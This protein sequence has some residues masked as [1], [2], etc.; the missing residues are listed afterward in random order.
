MSKIIIKKGLNSIFIGI[1]LFL[2]SVFCFLDTELPIG[3]T[4]IK[5]KLG[6]I[7]LGILLFLFT[8]LV[9]FNKYKKTLTKSRFIFA[10]ETIL[11]ILL[12]LTGFFL[13]AMGL[14]S[15]ET[16]KNEHTFIAHFLNFN[17][18]LALLVLVHSFVS[19]HIE[20]FK[21]EK[22][23]SFTFYLVMFGCGSYAIGTEL[24]SRNTILKTLAVLSF[25][26][27]LFHFFVAIQ[28]MK[29]H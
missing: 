7:F 4:T 14:C 2:V 1:L 13:P 26:Y 27:A 3:T 11:F 22:N 6:D 10:F 23:I 15:V 24:L 20:Y 19:L 16:F 9:V 5:I 8:Y 29:K 28:K 12:I 21:K 17:K 25:F 18:C